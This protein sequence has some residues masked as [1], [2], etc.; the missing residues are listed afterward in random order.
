MSDTREATLMVAIH[1]DTAVHH[2]VNASK[3]IQ[4]LDFYPVDLA[5]RLEYLDK[6]LNRLN[7]VI[8]DL[9]ELEETKVPLE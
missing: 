6:A 4:N 2:I 7:S 9:H 3:A 5:Y 8:E 1:L